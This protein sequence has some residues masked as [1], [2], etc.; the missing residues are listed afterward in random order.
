RSFRTVMGRHNWLGSPSS[1]IG[2]DAVEMPMV[3]CYPPA[4]FTTAQE[5]LEHARRCR[6][7][8]RHTIT[9]LHSVSENEGGPSTQWNFETQFLPFVMGLTELEGVEF[10]TYP[11]LIDMGQNTVRGFKF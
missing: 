6:D 1:G 7:S 9:L 11:E 8:Q 3:P 4:G 2:Y 10:V 5:A